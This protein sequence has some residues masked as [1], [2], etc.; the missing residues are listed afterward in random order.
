MF[1]YQIPFPYPHAWRHQRKKTK[2]LP[3]R[4][5]QSSNLSITMTNCFCYKCHERIKI[6]RNIDWELVSI[7]VLRNLHLRWVTLRTILLGTQQNFKLATIIMIIVFKN[8]IMDCYLG[9]KRRTFNILNYP[10]QHYRGETS[11][12]E[13]NQN[14]GRNA[15]V[16]SQR[17]I[18]GL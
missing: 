11:Y 5:S 18:S 3:S 4:S 2:F 15:E 7:S 12:S 6:I 9:K 1:N 10:E 8:K 13:G 17:K 16:G 14:C